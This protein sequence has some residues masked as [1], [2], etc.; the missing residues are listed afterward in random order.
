MARGTPLIAVRL[1]PLLR[2]AVEAALL[3]RNQRAR[4]AAWTLSDFIRVAL[5]DKLNHYSRS[6]RP[7][8]APRGGPS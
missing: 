2:M 7:R 1:A 5:E 3:S 8:R 6:R 4:G